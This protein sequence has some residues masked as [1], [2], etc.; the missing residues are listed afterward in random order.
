MTRGNDMLTILSH[1]HREHRQCH[2]DIAKTVLSFYAKEDKSL[3]GSLQ[4]ILDGDAYIQAQ[5]LSLLQTILK[6]LKKT[7]SVYRRLVLYTIISAIK[8]TPSTA[9]NALECFTK[10]AADPNRTG[11]LILQ[12]FAYIIRKRIPL[13]F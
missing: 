2:I 12:T 6:E 11:K 13:L 8:C 4:K 7:N 3:L 1:L 5:S 10:E 9:I